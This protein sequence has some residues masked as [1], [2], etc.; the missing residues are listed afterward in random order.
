MTKRWILVLAVSA[1]FLPS[2]GHAQEFGITQLMQLLTQV[3]ERHA[4]FT[5]EKRLAALTEPLVA[6][7]D[8]D[9]RAPSYLRK[10][11]LTPVQ[12]EET[13]EVDGNQLQLIKPADKINQSLSLDSYP[14]I[15]IM[16]AAIRGSLSG[17][18]ATL[19]EFYEV[20]FSGTRAEWELTLVPRS[21]RVREF[22]RVINIGGKDDRLYR[23]ETV[24]GS[25]DSSLMTVQFQDK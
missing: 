1:W 22:L 10:R 3:K 19:R 7:G 18:I 11:T 20:G 9:Y 15:K 5:E 13:I 17:D 2:V 12:A 21:K 24:E 23:V 16:V 6:S 8:L 25:G 14:E 4:T